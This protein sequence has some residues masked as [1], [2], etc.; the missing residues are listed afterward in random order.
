MGGWLHCSCMDSFPPE[1]ILYHKDTFSSQCTTHAIAC[2]TFVHGA[3]GMKNEEVVG[4]AV[5]M[6]V[7]LAKERKQESRAIWR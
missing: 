1:L 7:Q 4:V 3:A 6:F 5:M 2:V